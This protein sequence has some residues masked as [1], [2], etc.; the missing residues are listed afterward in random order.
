MFTNVV[1]DVGHAM[2][3]SMVRGII[4]YHAYH[5]RLLVTY[6]EIA[7]SLNSLPNGGQL[8]QALRLITEDD[9]KNK[10]PLS[11]AVV[12]NSQ[13]NTPGEGFFTQCLELGYDVPYETRYE[14]WMSHLTRLD[15]AP[16]TLSDHLD[17]AKRT[18]PVERNGG[19]VVP[20][21][22]TRI[23]PGYVSRGIVPMDDAQG[24]RVV[25][26]IRQP[27]ESRRVSDR[28]YRKTTPL[29]VEVEDR[30]RKRIVEAAHSQIDTL[31]REDDP[32]SSLPT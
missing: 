16:L 23:G 31:L 12:V 8:G 15:V 7:R 20:Q 26:N 11:T 9:F 5:L 10:R 2:Y 4:L 19:Y 21:H 18:A 24:S 27:I 14:F 30:R 32:K 22:V 1:K 6:G 25:S 28:P 13:D 17:V 3:A 29:P